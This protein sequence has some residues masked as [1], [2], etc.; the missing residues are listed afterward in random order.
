MSMEFEKRKIEFPFGLLGFENFKHFEL[1]DSE[2]KPFMWLQ[3]EDDKSL[4]FLVVD[5]FIFF[6]DYELDVDNNSLSQ[7]G[8]LSPTDVVVLTIITIPKDGKNLTANLEG[9]LVI[10]K[11][12]N[13]GMQV[14]LSDPKWTTKHILSA[15]SVKGG[16]KC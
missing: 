12:T 13:Q 6:N 8:L 14:V 16:G 10:N 1:A 3:S 7:I 4:A 9:P 5:P 2:F 15:D 11:N